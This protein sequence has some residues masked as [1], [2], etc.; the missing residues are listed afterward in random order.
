MSENTSDDSTPDPEPDEPDGGARDDDLRLLVELAA[1]GDLSSEDTAEVERLIADRPALLA[2]YDRQRAAASAAR[3]TSSAPTS[4]ASSGASPQSGSPA[5]ASSPAAGAPMPGRRPGN[6]S[7]CLIGLAGFVIAVIAVVTIGVLVRSDSSEEPPADPIAAVLDDPDF[8]VL[9]LHG[10][11][12][13]TRFGELALIYS[14]ATHD[15]VLSG[16]DIPSGGELIS[17]SAPERVLAAFPPGEVRTLVADIDPDDVFEV[18]AA[19]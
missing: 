7:G 9:E 19:P 16:T 1:H 14:P 3:S 6:Q 18:R 15:A 17:E 2:E 5:P 4:A 10:P 8:R 12:E 11:D 13:L